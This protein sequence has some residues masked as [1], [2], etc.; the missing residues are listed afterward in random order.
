MQPRAAWYIRLGCSVQEEDEEGAETA[1]RQEKKGLAEQGGGGQL[2]SRLITPMW[3]VREREREG[4]R[5]KE[6]VGAS[7]EKA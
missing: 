6:C 4:K 5:V 7:G 1:D 3:P 2:N